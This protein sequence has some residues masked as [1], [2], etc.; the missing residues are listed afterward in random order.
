MPTR[1][2]ALAPMFLARITDASAAPAHQFQEVWVDATGTLVDKVGGEYGGADNPGYTI[3]GSTLAVSAI[4]IVRSAENAAGTLFELIPVGSAPAVS[5]HWIEPAFVRTTFT[6]FSVTYA[7]GS[8]GVGATLTGSSNGALPAQD[9]VTPFVGMRLLVTNQPV[10]GGTAL[11]N[12]VY[13]VNRVGD[14]SHTFLMT[15]TTDSDSADKFPG[16][17]VFV[18]NGKIFAGTIYE[19]TNQA[20]AVTVGTTNIAYAP[21]NLSSWKNACDVA[22]TTAGTLATDFENGD[23]VDGVTLVTGMRALIKDQS[24]VSENGIYI[25][26]A[27]GAPVRAAQAQ[28]GSGIQLLDLYGAV[29]AVARG[30]VNGPSVWIGGDTVLGPTGSW[31]RVGPPAGF[32]GTFAALT[33]TVTV[34]N[35]LTVSVV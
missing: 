30:T 27:S 10:V 28:S 2:H 16:Q 33:Q 21:V 4:C 6:I 12:G 34:V 5:S 9:G 3:D 15:R 20:Q 13:V 11:Q 26:Q 18:T 24:S 31:F 17:A 25:V 23:S 32:S 22:T 1:P 29:V 14:A 8:S 35:G 19:C 7:N